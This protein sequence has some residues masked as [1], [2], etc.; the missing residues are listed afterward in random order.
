MSIVEVNHVTK[1]YRL[2]AM[3]GFKQ[4]LLN[5][6]AQLTGKELLARPLFKVLFT[7]AIE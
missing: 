4:T 5:A 7:L 3:Q 1:E 2:G 6:A